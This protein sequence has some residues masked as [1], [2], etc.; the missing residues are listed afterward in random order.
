MNLDQFWNAI[1]SQLPGLLAAL[2]VAAVV[3]LGGLLANVI[4]GRA[5]LLLAARTSLTPADVAPARNV[6]RWLVRIITAIIVLGVFGFELGGLW[7]MISTVLAMIAIGFVAV[8]SMLS[9]TSATVLLVLMRPF[10]VGDDIE[11]PSENVRGRVID[12]N[13]FFTTLVDHEGSELRVP[14]NIFFQK[15][16]RRTAGTSAITLAAQLNSPTPA[17]VGLPPPPPPKNSESRKPVSASEDFAAKSIPDPATLQ[18][19]K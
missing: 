14:N 9:N 8:W 1:A 18:P 5:L 15:V 6:L 13:F 11:L 12:L 3:I 2:P 7:A 19:K 10:R 17:Q 4:I 16:V